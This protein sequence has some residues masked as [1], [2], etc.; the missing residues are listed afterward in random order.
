MAVERIL[1]IV[2]PDAGTKDAIA[3]DTRQTGACG[4]R[5]PAGGME[6]V[7]VGSVTGTFSQTR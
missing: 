6:L 7:L 1:D 4:R 2:R 3:G 5:T